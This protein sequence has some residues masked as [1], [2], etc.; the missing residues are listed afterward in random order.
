MARRSGGWLLLAGVLL[1][2]AGCEERSEDFGDDA[3]RSSFREVMSFEANAT[4]AHLR[5]ASCRAGGNYRKWLCFGCD[6][7]TIRRIRQLDEPPPGE[8]G[9][10]FLRGV[11]GP[12]DSDGTRPDEPVWWKQP[13]TCATMSQVTIGKSGANGMSVVT[14][15]WTDER[16]HVVYARRLVLR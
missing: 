4:V 14:D 3:L 2:L 10:T 12:G 8:N 1:G 13:G 15:I 11:D 9:L 16:N 5:C 7:A 6:D